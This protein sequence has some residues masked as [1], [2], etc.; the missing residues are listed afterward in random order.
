MDGPWVFRRVESPAGLAATGSV[1]GLPKG[2]V[3]AFY[4]PTEV[5]AFRFGLVTDFWSG[6]GESGPLF[7]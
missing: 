7:A 2:G 6:V 4:G 1:D 3:S 5:G